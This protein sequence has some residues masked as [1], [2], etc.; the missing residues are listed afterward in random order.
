MRLFLLT[1]DEEMLMGQSKG[2]VD[3]VGVFEVQSNSGENR[4]SGKHFSVRT[5][6]AAV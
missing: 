5:T 2:H 1:A 4:L 3:R 6:K